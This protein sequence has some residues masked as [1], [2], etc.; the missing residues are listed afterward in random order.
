MNRRPSGLQYQ[1]LKR[2]NGP[3]PTSTDTVVCHY[4]GTLEN[5]TECDSSYRRGQPAEFRVTGVIK[6][7][8]EALKM[9]PVG[10]RWRLVIPPNLAYGEKGAGGKIGPNATLIFEIELLAIKGR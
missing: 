5:G 8:T 3:K 6:G 7:W 4:R 1:I 10:S 2:G 9:M